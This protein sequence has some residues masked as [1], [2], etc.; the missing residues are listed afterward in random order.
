MQLEILNLLFFARKMSNKPVYETGWHD[1]NQH[2]PKLW[3][4]L[5]YNTEYLYIFYGDS[6]EYLKKDVES[7]M[8]TLRHEQV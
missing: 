5:F 6:F 4:C 7:F 3:R 8:E 2:W 1:A